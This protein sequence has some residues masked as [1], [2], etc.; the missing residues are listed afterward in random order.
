MNE[1]IQHI[2]EVEGVRTPKRKRSKKEIVESFEEF[3][4]KRAKTKNASAK[5]PAKKAAPKTTPKPAAAKNADTKPAPVYA[6][7]I[8]LN[9]ISPTGYVRE[10]AYD[11]K[12]K[13]FYVAFAKS[14]W[15]MPSNAD[16]WKAFEKAVADPLTEI[17][18]YYRKTFRG[19]TGSMLAVRK[20][21]A[22]T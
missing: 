18:A 4:T 22:K 15:A 13:L 14:T 3:K 6:E 21:E 10:A 11:P 7:P 17:D 16:E 5:K 19:R 2:A 12:T 1:F 20:P 8:S 9:F